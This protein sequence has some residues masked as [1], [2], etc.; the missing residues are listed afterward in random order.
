MKREDPQT[1]GVGGFNYNVH[2]FDYE[3]GLDVSAI[4]Q[5]R[6]CR[7]LEVRY[8][9]IDHW[10]SQLDFAPAPLLSDYTS[11]LHSAEVNLRRQQSER[12]STLT[13]FRFVQL[14]EELL[15]TVVGFPFPASDVYNNLY[16]FQ[17]GGQYTLW[18]CCG[19]L[20][21]TTGG[22]AGIYYNDADVD[23]VLFVVPFSGSK[24][25]MSFV[26]E[27]DITASLQ[28]TERCSLR[29][30]YECLWLD[31]VAQVGGQAGNI[32]IGNGMDMSS[33]VFYHGA[34]VGFELTR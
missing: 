34:T 23:N 3:G 11:K 19:L 16:G 17:V 12:L 8:C 21:I 18:D 28:L 10:G 25:Y 6:N 24:D 29:C 7:D 15:N 27:Y 20:R 32:A 33:T 30:G 1:T 26:G 22:K 13:G 14:N 4:R 31:G 9:G 2:D 5:L